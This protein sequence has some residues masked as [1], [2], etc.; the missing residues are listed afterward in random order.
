MKQST[1]LSQ[2][3]AGYSAFAA[4]LAGFASS[5]DAQ[6]VHVDNPDVTIINQPQSFD[7]DGDGTNDVKFQ[8]IVSSMSTNYATI[9]LYKV[10]L[11][12]SNTN[13]AFLN[14]SYHVKLLNTDDNI[15]ANDAAF[16]SINDFYFEDNGVKFVGVKFNGSGKSNIG[17]I[18]ISV[19]SNRKSITVYDWAYTPFTDPTT[20]IK[21]GQTSSTPTDI[22]P[23]VV[24]SPLNVSVFPTKVTDKVSISTQDAASYIITNMAGT[25]IDQGELVA[26]E[27]SVNTSQ[28]TKGI[29]LVKVNNSKGSAVK[30]IVKE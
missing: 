6:I 13:V 10:F 8:Q 3:L 17:W 4:A 20:A 7:L 29:Y 25:T 27:N 22:K 1:P 5:A 28:L 21:A 18:R 9:K 26:G 11:T 19:A 15:Q 14:S 30:R 16:G 23:G 24:I 2:K 12:R